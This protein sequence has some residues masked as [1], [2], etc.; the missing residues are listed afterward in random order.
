MPI[1][2]RWCGTRR[3]PECDGGEDS[4]PTGP[5]IAVLSPITGG[6]YFGGLYA[7]ITR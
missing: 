2:L 3:P 5:T 4:V 6:F 1:D 7:W